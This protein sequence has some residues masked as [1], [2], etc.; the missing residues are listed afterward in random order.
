MKLVTTILFLL[1][2]SAFSQKPCD[3]TTDV[4]DSIGTY[5]STKEYL[6]YEKIFA[7]KS[8]YIFNSL[9]IT[10]GI[11][12]LSVQFLDKSFD[13]IKA[14][15]F[16]KNSRIYLQLNNGKIVTLLHIDQ[17]VCGSMIRDEKGMNNRI[18]TGNFLFMKDNYDAL[19]ESPISFMRVKYGMDTED[20]IYK[21]ELISELNKETY[22]PENYFLDYFHCLETAN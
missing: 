5:K 10:D 4:N 6:V 7:G 2:F 3:F 14:R 21:T 22:H 12:L 8:S 13:F 9:V 1:T 11:P 16:D 15:C 18:L 17:D 20:Y 19:K